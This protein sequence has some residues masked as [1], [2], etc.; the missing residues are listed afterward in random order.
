[1]RIGTQYPFKGIEG[2]ALVREFA[3][4]VP[5]N[6][7]WVTIHSQRFPHAQGWFLYNRDGTVSCKKVPGKIGGLWSFPDLIINTEIDLDFSVETDLEF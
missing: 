5:A 6:K 7:V 1:M 3:V 2:Y 4:C